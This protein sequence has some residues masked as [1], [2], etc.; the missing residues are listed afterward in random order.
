MKNHFKNICGSFILG[1][2]CAISAFASPTVDHYPIQVNPDVVAMRYIQ[3]PMTLNSRNTR[4]QW[5]ALLILRSGIIADAD[6]TSLGTLSQQKISQFQAS[7]STCPSRELS[8]QNQGIPFQSNTS[9]VSYWIRANDG[10]PFEVARSS[11]GHQY[12]LDQCPDQARGIV[13]AL[14][15]LSILLKM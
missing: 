13:S 9:Y 2:L 3:S 14:D 11:Q 6:G 8:D 1:S 10:T 4:P 7:M 15:G 12:R 5:R